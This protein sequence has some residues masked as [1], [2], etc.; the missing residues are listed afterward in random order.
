MTVRI[1]HQSMTDLE[2]LPGYAAMLA[3]HARQ[4]GG[5]DFRVDLHGVHPE[6]YPP[7]MAPVEMTKYRWAHHLVFTQFVENAIRAQAEGYDAV[8][9][10]CFVD[11]ALELA[12]S[13]VDIPV[14]SSCE[15]ALLVS[16]TIG[17]AFGLITIDQSMVRILHE[18]VARYGFADRVRVITTLDPPMDEFELDEAFAGRGPLVER[19]T[20]EARRLIERHDIDVLIPA[21]GVLNTMLVRN[22]VRAIDGVPVVDS[23]GALLQF[24]DMMVRLRKTT[25][26]GT[27]RRMAY[28]KPPAEMMQHL[29]R[30]TGA[31]LEQAA[32]RLDAPRS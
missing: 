31:V 16:A 2:R 13:V 27:A 28:A 23:Y 29:R 22:R 1:W 25:G 21:E 17:T 15:T 10:S 9:I 24:A 7:G 19:F 5:A 32:S 26:L 18:L 4:V 6:T 3:E 12:R 11:P 14:V 30:L 8:A 20:A